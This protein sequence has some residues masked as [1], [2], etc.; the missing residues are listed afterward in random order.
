M[1]NKI[2]NYFLESKYKKLYKKFKNN[3]KL[4]ETNIYDNKNIIYF[5]IL[6][7]NINFL[8]KLILL[9]NKIILTIDKNNNI[10]P[11]YAIW[12]SLYDVF[13]YLIDKIIELN[14]N[15]ILQMIFNNEIILDTILEKNDIEL[16]EKY[17]NKYNKYIIWYND[18]LSY[19]YKLIINYKNDI[20]KII[21]IIGNIINTNFDL[22]KFFKYPLNNYPLF[23]I[24]YYYYKPSIYNI[25]TKINIE[26]IKKFISYYPNQ[27]NYENE[28]NK[29]VIYYIAEMN[30][31]ELLDFCIKNN[32]NINHIA[33]ISVYGY[34]N[35]C[36]HIIN[37]CNIDMIKYILNLELD[38]NFVNF[39][40]ETP[41]YSLV[42]NNNINDNDSIQLIIDL[43]KKTDDWNNINIYGQTIIHLLCTKTYIEKL[44]DI[45]KT[46]YFDI[47]FKNRF[48]TSPL[49][50]L[51]NTFKLLKYDNID[52]KIKEFKLL[53][54]DNYIN[55]IISSKILDI[56]ANIKNICKNINNDECKNI[57]LKLLDKPN[58]TNIYHIDKS[59]K[60]ILVEDYPYVHYNIYNAKNT[61]IY[62]YYILLVSKFN[63]LNIP[64]N[65]N[66]IDITQLL[67][68]SNISNIDLVNIDDL[69][70]INIFTNLN[71][72]QYFIFLLNNSL[73][74]DILYAMNIYWLSDKYYIIP[75]NF[76]E[77]I[78]NSIN[79]NYNIIICRIN[80]IN[81]SLHA[82]T[83]LIDVFNKRIIR[84]EPHGRINYPGLDN[85][86]NNIFIQSEYFKNYKY[87][88]PSDYLPY[89]S[90]QNVSQ[91]LN[92]NHIRKG[93]IGG[94]CVAWCIWFI[95][96]YIKNLN[97]INTDTKFKSIIHKTIKKIINN[98]NLI[99]EYIRNYANYLYKNLEYFIKINKI[100]DK[101]IDIY[102]EHYTDD[103]LLNFYNLI[104]YSFNNLI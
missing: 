29:T 100:T 31:I 27:L 71:N 57:V 30:D 83:L 54:L 67:K 73:T 41:I 90:F 18:S 8:D 55:T 45:L 81:Y 86:I 26:S 47:N 96:F 64:I 36:H 98:G 21:D 50:I 78:I 61:D 92:N 63:I 15:K 44:Y 104:S 11:Y 58:M 25:T 46:K 1:T 23:I 69:Y 79:H 102:Y 84:F 68:N 40:N 51:I 42:R 4:L 19:L 5:I 94:Y 103:E 93:D 56:P 80:I 34:N 99:D 28:S 7:N 52:D 97:I 76:I 66:K 72:F 82:N 75:Y 32:A 43:L 12:N 6:S 62:I 95:E 59:Y 88:K 13:F 17:I 20:N 48:S 24:I 9:D 33:F 74:Y 2:Y 10:Y 53:V 101:N 87:F 37:I 22:E 70:K 38:F 65:N 49:N 91:E 14:D 85:A 60:E 39:Y 3:P 77:S 89:N 16:F 35:L